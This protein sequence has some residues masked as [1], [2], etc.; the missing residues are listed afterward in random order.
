[1]LKLEDI[2]KNAAISGIEPGHVVRVVTTD[3]ASVHPACETEACHWG[4]FIWFQGE[5]DS[6]DMANASEYQT[7]LE[8]LIA[9]VRGEVGSPSLPIIIIQIGGWAQ[10][11]D[12]GPTIAAIQQAVVDADPNA[13]LVVTS[14][15]SGFYHYDPAA[16][17]IIGR[18][19]AAAVEDALGCELLGDCGA[20]T[21]SD[22]GSSAGSGDGSADTGAGS[23]GAS[24][25][26]GGGITSDG[27]DA[28]TGAD[29]TDT[30][31]A[32]GSSGAVGETPSDAGCGCRSETRPA[33]SWA[34]LLSVAAVH[35]R[36]RRRRRPSNASASTTPTPTD[37][38]ATAHA[39]S[40]SP[41]HGAS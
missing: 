29:A 2:K 19:V 23:G 12:F 32:D 36:T 37:V 14:D 39:P 3:P 41:K 11:L 6:F 10:S 40:Q 34:T 38:Q 35:R 25:G 17:L 28:T 27:G 21:G 30:G 9:D 8:N 5:N 7:D 26:D 22:G 16:Q 18:R 20:S 4:A 15:L 33:W 31:A 24:S 13:R 1:M